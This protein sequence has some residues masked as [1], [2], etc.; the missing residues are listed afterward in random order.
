METV[1]DQPSGIRHEWH[2]QITA[3]VAP[4]LEAL[5]AGRLR[6]IMP[7]E[8]AEGQAEYCARVCHLEI[9][10]RSLAGLSPWL[11]LGDVPIHE[12]A[13]QS[14]FRDLARAAIASALD[15]KSP[16]ALQFDIERQNLVDAAFLAHAMLRAPDALF[17]KLD[18]P[19]QSRL[20]DGF[21]ASRQFKPH[22]CNWLLFSALIEAALFLFTGDCQDE[23][24]EHAVKQ[25][26]AWYLGDGTYGDGP[27]FHADYYNSYVIQPMLLDTLE[28]VATR[29]PGWEKLIPAVQ[30]RAK[31]FA[32]VQERMIGTEGTYPPLGRSITYR[33][34]AFQTLAQMALREELAPEIS[35]A[36]VRGALSAV[37]RRT[38]N[39]PGTFDQDGW[40]QIGLAGHQPSLGERYINTGSLYLCSTIFLPL[41]LPGSA[42]F[43]ADPD[44]PWTSVKLWSGK[45]AP[46]DHALSD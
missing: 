45:D 14:R 43:W 39:A 40:L 35:P 6:K 28:A 32:A 20:I 29:N 10:G 46:A 22:E 33:G 11:A 16:D 36:Q 42:P 44:Q 24:I 41:G 18:A 13:S 7:R 12:A 37:I 26:E 8:C 2:R 21:K 25:H 23:T 30:S 34:G 9:L 3:L 19:T 4:P 31:R 15:P 38:M 27:V 5:A 17:T 1:S